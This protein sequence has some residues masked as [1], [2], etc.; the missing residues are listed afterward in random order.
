MATDNHARDDA[1]TPRQVTPR[2]LLSPRRF[3][4]VAKYLYAKWRLTD[5][6]LEWPRRLYLDHIEVFNGFVEPDGSGK[7][8]PDAF[9][10]S[11][12][13]LIDAIAA[14][15]FDATR[16]QVPLRSDGEIVNGAH[17]LAACL[18]ANRPVTVCDAGDEPAYVYDHRWFQQRGL[19]LTWAD[20]MASEICHLLTAPFV[21]VIYP[22]ASGRDDLLEELIGNRTRIWY[23]KH[24]DLNENGAINLVQQIYRHEPWVGGPHNDFK[25]AR[26]KMRGCFA[27]PGPVRAYLVDSDLDTIRL[28]K[29]DIR[30]AFDIGNH[31]VHINDTHE[32]AGELAGLLFNENSV[33]LLN[34]RRR[35]GLPWFDALLP[36]Y[37]SALRAAGATDGCCI[38]GSGVLAAFGMR[39]VADLDFMLDPHV[40]SPPFPV[41]QI[42]PHN[43]Q[44]HWYGRT[45]A[46]L[47]HDPTLQCCFN[48][49]KF[50]RIEEV[51]AM[52]ARRGEAKDRADV[53]LI[54]SWS[55]TSARGRSAI[56]DAGDALS[57]RRLYQ[58]ARFLKL[59]LRLLRHRLGL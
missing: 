40:A 58:R 25:G 37:E 43:T 18:A 56:R 9:L 41:P 4:V 39:D 45:P 13:S 55:V 38:D 8:G 23:R 14:D 11:F 26:D 24:I 29:A 32:E 34:A 51:R 57:W 16:S 54:D 10:A 6:S 35:R 33:H 20:V 5:A 48:G 27:R 49:L 3:D 59:R 53:E 44:A 2:S 12:D 21:I 15:G 31:S 19:S 28:L 52:K 17:R 1:A 7:H 47:V 36:A 50:L 46:A 42:S 22:S 30:A